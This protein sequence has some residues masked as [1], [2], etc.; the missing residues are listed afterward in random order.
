M[1]VVYSSLKEVSGVVLP[2]KWFIILDGVHTVC[3]RV[4]LCDS[5]TVVKI[6]LNYVIPLQEEHSCLIFII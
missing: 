6:L 2:W 4:D 1:L 5:L 3:V